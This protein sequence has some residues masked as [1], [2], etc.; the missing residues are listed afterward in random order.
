MFYTKTLCFHFGTNTCSLN[1]LVPSSS[2]SVFAIFLS[3]HLRIGILFQALS[4][5][6]FIVL[7]GLSAMIVCQLF[8]IDAPGKLLRKVKKHFSKFVCSSE[9]E[10]SA[11]GKCGL[12]CFFHLLIPWCLPLNVYS[13]KDLKSCNKSGEAADLPNSECAQLDSKA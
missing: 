10:I 9:T 8:L 1:F 3:W 11:G 6:Q 13:L 4:I 2:V 12:V 5:P 7:I